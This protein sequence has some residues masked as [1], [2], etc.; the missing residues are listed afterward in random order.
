MSMVIEFTV[1]KRYNVG[2]FVNE[3]MY[4]VDVVEASPALKTPRCGV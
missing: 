4:G 3:P 1:T 2:S